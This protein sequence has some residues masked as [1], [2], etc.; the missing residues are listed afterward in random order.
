VRVTLSAADEPP[1]GVLLAVEDDGP[2]VP[3]SL[4][5]TLFNPFVTTKK[6]GTGL[7]LAFSRKVVEAHGG[8]IEVDRSIELGGA[9]FRIHMPY[10]P[11]ETPAED[12]K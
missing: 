7:G 2:G 8:S 11:F 9:R 3:E 5:E 12:L 4:C 6:E 10:S 1:A